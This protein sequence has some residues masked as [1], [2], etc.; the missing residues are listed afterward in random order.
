MKFDTV[1]TFCVLNFVLYWSST[2]RALHDFRSLEKCTS[3]V[4]IPRHLGQMYRK[5]YGT[6][7]Q[8]KSR[9]ERLRAH[10]TTQFLTTI[11]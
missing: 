10:V 6:E 1:T 9:G 11:V 8:N 3:F 5:T 2:K 4:Y 7:K